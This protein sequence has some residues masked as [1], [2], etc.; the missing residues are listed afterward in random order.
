MEV[1]H[2]ELLETFEEFEVDLEVDDDF[3]ESQGGVG[4]WT[5][6]SQSLGR[7]SS[8][9]SSSNRQL[10]QPGQPGQH[11][12]PAST[13]CATLNTPVSGL[14][15]GWTIAARD[16]WRYQFKRPDTPPPAP[17]P[18]PDVC[19]KRIAPPQSPLRNCRESDGDDDDTPKRTALRVTQRARRVETDRCFQPSHRPLLPTS[20]ERELRP[21]RA[22]VKY[23]ESDDDDSPEWTAPR[24]AP[25]ARRVAADRRY[26]ATHRVRRAEYPK[27]L[28]GKAPR[29][30]MSETNKRYREQH[31]DRIREKDR[32]YFKANQERIQARQRQYRESHR[33]ELR[34]KQ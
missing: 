23:Y 12:P 24:A 1:A 34:E 9:G 8:K 22:P 33:E 26:Q 29:A 2:E 5:Q 31:R 14:W 15:R 18:S 13:T 20:T 4:R 11:E 6:V 30:H 25:R 27:A 16:Y 19:R 32:Q 7:S 21:R 3:K 17:P 10:R 28:P